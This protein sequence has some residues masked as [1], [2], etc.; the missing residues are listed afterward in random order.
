MKYNDPSGHVPADT[1]VDGIFLAYDGAN[2]LLN[3]SEENKENL[4]WSAAATAI[5]YVPGRYVK[6]LLKYVSP[7]DLS[8]IGKYAPDALKYLGYSDEFAYAVKR[9]DTIHAATNARG[10][11]VW[12]AEGSVEQNWGWSHIVDKHKLGQAGDEFSKAFGSQYDDVGKSKELIMEATEKGTYINHPKKGGAYI[13]KV[14]DDYS[15]KVAVNKHG[16]ITTAHPLRENE[17]KK[18]IIKYGG[19][20]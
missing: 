11:T 17:A 7:S 15:L 18:E 1:I 9:G 4:E 12:L 5:P 19:K 3:P 14:N 2:Y 10:K 6:P 20:K 16:S 13:M 8:K